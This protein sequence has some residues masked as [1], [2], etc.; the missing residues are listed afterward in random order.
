MARTGDGDLRRKGEDRG[1][2]ARRPRMTG[3]K[4]AGEDGGAS[5]STSL[6]MAKVSG[7]RLVPWVREGV[8][9]TRSGASFVC[10]TARLARRSM[11][12]VLH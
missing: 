10:S 2:G 8:M 9:R 11:S 6:S 1:R 4:G 12:T 3:D 7:L 5:S